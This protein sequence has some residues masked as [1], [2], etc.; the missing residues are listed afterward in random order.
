MK[1]EI[2]IINTKQAEEYLQG[3]VKPLRLELSKRDNKMVFVYNK[4]DTNEVWEKWKAGSIERKKL[5]ESKSCM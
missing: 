1:N 4:D 3:G 5:I 2:Y